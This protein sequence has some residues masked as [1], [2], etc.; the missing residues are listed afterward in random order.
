[1]TVLFL[2]RI[3]QPL[4]PTEADPPAWIAAWTAA[5]FGLVHLGGRMLSR[6]SAI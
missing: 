1:M 4:E 2:R 5:A 6:R 3:F